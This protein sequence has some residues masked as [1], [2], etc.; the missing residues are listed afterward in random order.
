MKLIFLLRIVISLILILLISNSYS[1]TIQK[2]T[3]QTNFT[4]TP[5]EIDGLMNDSCWNKVE[6]RFYSDPAL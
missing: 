5:P 6:W 2:K 4:K 3:Y 1:Q